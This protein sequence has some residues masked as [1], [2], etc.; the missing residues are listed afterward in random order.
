M[1]NQEWELN[2]YLNGM[3]IGESLI[4]DSKWLE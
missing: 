4:T 1:E 3:K 2:I